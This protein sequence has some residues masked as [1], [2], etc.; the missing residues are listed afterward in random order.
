MV[1]RYFL[2]SFLI[3]FCVI[4]CKKINTD[5]GISP[6]TFI[7]EETKTTITCFD[8]LGKKV[9]ITKRPQRVIVNY[10]SF[11][12][13]WYM[14]GG[15]AI[16][17][18]NASKH[19]PLPRGT[20]NLD[21]TGHVTNP[22]VEKILSLAPDFVILSRTIDTHFG[23][24]EILTDNNIETIMLNYE[25]YNDFEKI[26]ELF[27]ALN[28][29]DEVLQTV[30]PQ[31][32]KEIS[33]IITDAP[34][35]QKPKFLALF[36]SPQNIRAESDRTNT[37]NMASLL[38]GINIV[39]A[40]LAGNKSRI[41]LNLERIILFDPDVILITPMGNVKKIEEALEKDFTTNKA[42]ETVRAVKEGN[43]HYL[44]PHLFLHKPNARYPEA[45][46]YLKHILYNEDK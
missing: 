20:E 26:L 5:T 30:I 35:E 28:E 6:D 8:A 24:R 27:A 40:E 10:M 13:L 37:G 41:M 4:S 17:R 16:G 9:I 29:N 21:T 19:S 33:T 23:L 42:W 7:I 34:R 15:T 45:F 46:S 12:D 25:N 11:I 31:L 14:A 1:L 38:G 3:C 32:K 22:N 39:D 18:P 43:I 36:A 2:Y 44:P